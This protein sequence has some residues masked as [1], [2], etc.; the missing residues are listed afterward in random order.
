MV[1]FGGGFPYMYGRNS[2]HSLL[3]SNEAATWDTSS[4]LASRSSAALRE[5]IAE[6]RT[7]QLEA[8][9]GHYPGHVTLDFMQAP[10][11]GPGPVFGFV[12]PGSRPPNASHV[13]K[14][15]DEEECSDL[16]NS[17]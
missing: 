10:G 7:R 17:F 5:L 15:E 16:W 1:T 13:T 4:E 11:P 3:S 6:T 12:P 2:A 8:S 14:S 9:H